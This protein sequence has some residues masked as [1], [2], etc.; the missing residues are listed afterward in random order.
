MAPSASK[1]VTRVQVERQ[2]FDVKDYL[3]SGTLGLAGLASQATVVFFITYFLIASGDTFR[4]KMVRIAGPAFS[5][6]KITS[7][8]S[9][10]SPGR[11]SAICWCRS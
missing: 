3:W 6:K 9:T 8:C 11:S 2:R 10:R 4:R 7:R 5:Q 1:G